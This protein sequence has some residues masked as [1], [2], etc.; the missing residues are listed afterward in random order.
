MAKARFRNTNRN[1]SVYR[2]GGKPVVRVGSGRSI[3]TEDEELKAA[4]RKSGFK[5]SSDSKEKK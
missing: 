1:V 2:E 3:T 5:E 4:L